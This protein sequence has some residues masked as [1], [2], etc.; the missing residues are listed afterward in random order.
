MCQ[1]F[2][3]LYCQITFHRKD[4]P[5]FMEPFTSWGTT[6]LPLSVSV[7]LRAPLPLRFHPDILCSVRT[8]AVE[9]MKDGLKLG[10]TGAPVAERGGSPSTC[11]GLW[12]TGTWGSQGSSHEGWCRQGTFLKKRQQWGIIQD[13]NNRGGGRGGRD[14]KSLRKNGTSLRS[15]CCW[16]LEWEQNGTDPARGLADVLGLFPTFLKT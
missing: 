14:R 13:R 9:W 16:A 4:E 12:C 5:H 11:P 15:K 3:R 8:W 6:G 7:W 1:Y 10:E 2:I